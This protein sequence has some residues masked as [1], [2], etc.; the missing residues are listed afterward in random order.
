MKRNQTLLATALITLGLAASVTVSADTKVVVLGTGTPVPNGERAGSSIAVIHNDEA[1]IF[2]IGAGVVQRAIQAYEQYD[3][4]ALYPTKINHLFLTHL[5]SDH[6][7]DFPELLGTYWWRRESQIQV[8]GPTG[9]QAMSDGA[10]AMLAKDTQTRL[11]DKSPVTNREA[12]RA[13]ITEFDEAG[14][15]FDEN[16][17]TV[18]AFPVTHGDW[19][20]SY[21]FKITTPDKTIVMSGDTSYN[22]EVK[23]QAEGADI[24]FHEAI[25]HEGWQN[26]SEEWQAYHQYAHSLTTEIAE[27]AEEAQPDL[28]VL[29]HVLHYGAP[30]EGVVDEV[31]Q[32]YTGEVVLAEDLAIFE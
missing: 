23:R 19:D 25:S 1:Y 10:N 32:H 12:Y 2:D 14:V 11:Q 8:F 24:L 16:G 18:E 6:I 21:G 9:T 15:V 28:L 20:L 17:I 7:L 22:D 26:L 27:L 3:I 29:Y 30:I 4:E 5:H 13:N 31:K